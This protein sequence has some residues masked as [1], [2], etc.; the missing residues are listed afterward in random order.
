MS[1]DAAVLSMAQ[2]KSGKAKCLN[3]VLVCRMIDQ[4]FRPVMVTQLGAQN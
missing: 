4:I 2:L 1:C 3:A